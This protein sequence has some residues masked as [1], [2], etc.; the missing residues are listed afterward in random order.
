MAEERGYI[1]LDLIV[2]CIGA[3]AVL[4]AMLFWH[5]ISV[6]HEHNLAVSEARFLAQEYM[7]K[8]QI[9]HRGETASGKV[10]VNGREY[11]II[12]SWT[13]SGESSAIGQYE[14]KIAWDGEDGEKNVAFRRILWKDYR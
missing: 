3:G 8:A 7:A 9:R 11:H 4:F 6:V 2:L 12:E 5:R 1:L 13:D 10:T 14:V